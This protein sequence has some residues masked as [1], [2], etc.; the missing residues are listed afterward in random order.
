M[1]S[2]DAGGARPPPAPG[3]DVA[4]AAIDATVAQAD[5]ATTGLSRAIGPV[6]LVAIGVAAVVGAGIFVV[7]GEAAATRAGP[8]VVVSFIIAGIVASLSAMCYAELAGMLPLAGSTYSYAYAALGTFVAWVIGWDL[9]VEYL[10]GAANVANGWSA[11]FSNMTAEMGWALPP[12]LL[13]GPVPGTDAEPMGW[14]N[15]PAVILVVLLTGVLISG[16]RESARATTFFVAV[17][18]ATLALFVGVGVF[19]VNSDNYHPFVPPNQGSFDEFGWT[20]VLAAAGLVFYGYIAFDAV[21]TAAQ[22][23][24]NPRRDVPIGVLGSL[25]VAT[26]LYVLVGLV[27]VGLVSYTTLNTPNALSTALDAVDLAWV[28]DVVDVGAVV[29][30]GASVLA[31]LYGQTR[32]LMRMSQDAMLPD[33]LGRVSSRTHTPTASILLCGGAAAVMAGILPSSILVELVS[34]GTLLAFT[35][36]SAAVIVLRRTRPDIPRR[37]RVPGGYVIPV[38]AAVSSLVIM[39]TLPPATWLRLLVWLLVG[40]V[41]YFTYSRSRAK[42]LLRERAAEPQGSA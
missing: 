11:Y 38:L 6:A 39:A 9:L 30:L 17:K 32:I 41:V 16:S 1:D 26:V 29:G 37:F 21:C 15:L 35:I 40:L 8:A 12:E 31:L 36:V 34:I 20:G 25:G 42:A 13:G 4:H 14:I 23:A 28:G 3:L 24:R 33:A 22:E 19:A 10:F 2:H 5:S 27:L 7:T 18:I